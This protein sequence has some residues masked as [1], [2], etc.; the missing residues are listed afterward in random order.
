MKYNDFS[1]DF[2]KSDTKVLTHCFHAYPAMMIP[3]IARRLL[4]KYGASA[5]T[6]FDPYCGS[7]TS[8]VEANVKGMNAIGTDL[9]P[10]ARLIAETKTTPID[11]QT[12]DLYLK[13]FNNYAFNFQFG[14]KSSDSVVIPQFKNIDFW[15]NKSSQEKLATI[16]KYIDHIKLRDI[17]NFFLTAFSETVRESSL[18]K[19]G[20]FKLVRIPND[21]IEQFNPDSF[22]IM[23]SKLMRN[24]T[25]LLDF[26]RIKRNYSFSKIYD[27]NTVNDIPIDIIPDNSIDI[28]ITSPPYGDSRTTVAYGQYSR[29]ANQWMGI[30]EASLVDKNLMGGTKYT[31]DFIF[32]S[33]HLR[34]TLDR[35]NNIDEKR[36]LEVESFFIDYS[37]SISNVSKTIK[38]NGHACYVVGNRTVKNIN[39]PMDLITK[40]FF[41]NN[42]FKHIETIVRNI[43]NKR[44]PSKNSPSN[45]PGKKSSTMK[46]EYIVICRKY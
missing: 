23:L 9:N 31:S 45:I 24:K 14:I 29:L 46:N 7:G 20:E 42:G 28:I 3:Q 11:I 36:R 2:R 43:P 40:E 6:L 1:W 22:G 34:D 35:I 41:K 5:K 17:R 12:L 30:K 26:I 44:M 10:L 21:K 39:I 32:N 33:T 16:K 27:F 4:L 13:D 8:L 18:T 15:F 37:N 38:K 19:K 25:G